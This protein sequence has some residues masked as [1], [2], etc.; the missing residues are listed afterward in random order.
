[1]L[2]AINFIAAKLY[3]LRGK[4]YEN[5]RKINNQR[6]LNIYLHLIKCFN[7]ILNITIPKHPSLTY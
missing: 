6:Y 1:M 5:L 3:Y 7:F 2:L 4:L